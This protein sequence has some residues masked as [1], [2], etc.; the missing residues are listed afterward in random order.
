MH[1]RKKAYCARVIMSNGNTNGSGTRNACERL[2]NANIASGQ[3]LFGSVRNDNGQ[4]PQIGE[5]VGR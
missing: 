3:C 4:F 1:A 2:C 5:K